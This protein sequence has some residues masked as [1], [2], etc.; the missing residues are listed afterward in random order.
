MMQARSRAQRRLNFPQQQQ[1]QG[2]CC[3]KVRACARARVCVRVQ[4]GEDVAPPILA[5]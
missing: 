4:N 1:R 5:H 3:A 2:R